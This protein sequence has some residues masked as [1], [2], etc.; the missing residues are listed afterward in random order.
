MTS[1]ELGRAAGLADGTEARAA[2]AKP[3]N[4]FAAWSYREEALTALRH[5]PAV[6]DSPV[7]YVEEY[8][9]AMHNMLLCVDEAA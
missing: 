2:G 7:E 3:D 6:V 8:R 9:I 1:K 4:H 5:E